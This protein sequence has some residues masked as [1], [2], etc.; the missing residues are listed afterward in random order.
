[1]NA[2]SEWLEVEVRR[3]GLVHHMRFERGKTAAPLTTIGKTRSTGTKVTFMPDAQIF[4]TTVFAWDILAN[5]LRE[6]AFLNK[7]IHIRLTQ[8]EPARE[9]IYHYKGG[10]EEFVRYLNQNKQPLHPKP[11]LIERSATA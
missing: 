10:V 2:L 1:V 7:G 11:V 8:E 6:M 4:T 5:R 9:E 3:N